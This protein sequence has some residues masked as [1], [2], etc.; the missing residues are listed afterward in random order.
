MKYATR[1]GQGL[2]LCLVALVASSAL[3]V[4]P[5]TV[6]IEGALSSK[7]GGPVADGQYAIT[8]R[9][10]T[11][12]TTNTASWT[13]KGTVDVKAGAFDHVLGTTTSLAPLLQLKTNEYWLGA[14][15]GTEPELPRVQLHAVFFAMRAKLS[16]G[17]ECTGCIATSALKP[18]DLDLKGGT[19]TVGKLN[20]DTVA[21]KTV[22]ASTVNATGNVK[23][24]A[25]EGDGSKLTGIKVPAGTCPQQQVVVGVDK[26]GKLVCGAASPLPDDGVDQVSQGL[27][28]V[29][30]DLYAA[31]VPVNVP[32][33][34]PIG[35]KATLT[36]PSVGAVNKLTV[37]AEVTLDAGSSGIDK[38]RVCLVGPGGAVP[39][40]AGFDANYCTGAKQYLLHEKSGSGKKLLG[41]WPS[42]N[43]VVKGDI[44]KDW[45]NK[46][47]AGTWTLQVID[48]TFDNNA[49][50][51][52]KI[53]KFVL[54]ARTTGNKKINVVKDMVVD[55]A[56]TVKGD[57][58]FQKNVAIDGN[59][60]VKGTING[61]V[62]GWV[63][64]HWGRMDC[65]T[66]QK[67]LYDGSGY[68]G[69][70][71]HS[72]AGT[73]LCLHPST[74]GPNSGTSS[75]DLLY[76][77]YTD[78][79][80]G[81]GLPNGKRIYCARCYEPSKGPCWVLPNHNVCPTGWKASYTGFMI[82]GHYQHSN[83][84]ERICLSDKQDTSGGSGGS[85]WYHTRVHGGEAS[86]SAHSNS[87]PHDKTVRC[88]LCC[89]Q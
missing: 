36:V 89:R 50:D 53:R 33:N 12:K 26:D 51:I 46:S 87:Y 60:T 44:T 23:A 17:V 15:V 28:Q 47:P 21:A 9:L 37:T 82:G 77:M 43:K 85:A 80:H 67:K 13:E 29:V 63:Y 1:I 57:G 8:F 73:P 18:G 20:A 75:S 6:G 40:N 52:G 66:G 31:T 25:F 72:G 64:T 48:T 59:L 78:H 27:V 3:A 39:N 81:T 7:G 32:D 86:G 45:T 38:L 30:G 42:P 4:G 74:P 84:G 71:G 88:A 49:A 10:Y 56:L 19:I 35:G 58:G 16:E 79:M 76:A 62:Q 55:G 11:S 65:P 68:S 41:T 5:M 22:G 54:S 70:H 2:A 24:A 69:H 14:Q 61:D 34:N 83:P